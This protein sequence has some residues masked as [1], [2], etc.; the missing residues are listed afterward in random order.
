MELNELIPA[1]YLAMAKPVNHWRAL[2]SSHSLILT[3]DLILTIEL[4]HIMH[5]L[6]CTTN[7]VAVICYVMLYAWVTLY[8]QWCCSDMLCHA[9]CTGYIV[10]PM[11]LQ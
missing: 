10:P 8:H 2:S 5:G 6:H 9:V 7:G 3:I 1:S 11:V 4:H